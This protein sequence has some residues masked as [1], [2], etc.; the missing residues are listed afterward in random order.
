MQNDLFDLDVQVKE[1]NQVQSDSVV[2][3]IICTTFCSV[4]WCQSNCC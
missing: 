1:V 2:S 3:D 4:T